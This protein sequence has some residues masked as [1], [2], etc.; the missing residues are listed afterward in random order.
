MGTRGSLPSPARPESEAQKIRSILSQSVAEGISNP[1]EIDRF[2]AR[3]PRERFA[4]YGGDTSCT[5]VTGDETQLII[6]A[7]SGIRQLGYELMAGPCGQGKGE[8]HLLFTHFHWDHLIGLPFFVPIFIPGNQIHVYSV[9]PELETVFKTL[10]KK[11]YFPVPLEQ[12]GARITYHSVPLR[13]KIEIQDLS[14]TSYAL[15]HPDPCYGF[16]IEKDGKAYSHCVD[17]EA[18]RHSRSELGEDLPLYQNIDLMLFDAQYTLEETLEKVDWGH[19]AATIGLDIAMREGIK[20]V[21]FV[22]HDPASS[23]QK[24]RDAEMETLKYY[25]AQLRIARRAGDDIHEV[26]W[27]FGYDGLQVD[28]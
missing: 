23:D 13:E 4:G 14:L 11:P 28:I 18:V 9:Q 6:D 8:V 19:A 17:T 3:L 15:D 24:I 2:L 26:D 21:I 27:S 10:F 20:K 16:K 1:K 25:E 7:G 12:L 22:H 5:E